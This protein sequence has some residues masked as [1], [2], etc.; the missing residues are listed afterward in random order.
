MQRSAENGAEKRVRR[1]YG[2]GE[3]G[4][5]TGVKKVGGASKKQ[6]KATAKK[7]APK[8][9]VVKKTVA[10]KTAKKVL[11]ARRKKK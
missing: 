5:G 3:A 10:K 2:G 9:K 6:T 1:R 11:T 8:K 7:L 4:K